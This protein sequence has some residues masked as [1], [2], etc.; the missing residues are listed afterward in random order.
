[1]TELENFRNS[2]KRLNRCDQFW[3]EMKPNKSGRLCAKCD[4]TIIDFSKM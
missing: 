1:M 3:D 4:K 2:L